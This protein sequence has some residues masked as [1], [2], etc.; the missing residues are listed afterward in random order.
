MASKNKGVFG[1]EAF[2]PASEMRL[3]GAH[4]KKFQKHP[5]GKKIS[6]M[7]TGI[8]KRHA[9]EGDGQHSSTYSISNINDTKQA[10]EGDGGKEDAETMV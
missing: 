10:N 5:I 8:K 1:I 2:K 9:V 4:A 6:M 7:V 3:E